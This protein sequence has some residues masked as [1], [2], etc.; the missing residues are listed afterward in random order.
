MGRAIVAVGRFIWR[1]GLV[2]LG[3]RHLGRGAALP[4]TCF[5]LGSPPIYGGFYVRVIDKLCKRGVGQASVWEFRE[6][7]RCEG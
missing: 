6:W 7:E 4:A 5:I 3:H 2:P 1:E